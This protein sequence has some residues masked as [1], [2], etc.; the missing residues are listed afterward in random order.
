MKT[1]ML[2]LAMLAGATLG[3]QTFTVTSGQISGGYTDLAQKTDVSGGTVAPMTS[4][5]YTGI[6]SPTG[7]NFPYLA[8]YFTSFSI[9]DN[10]YIV[11]GPNT[12]TTAPA[13]PNAYMAPGFFI[14]PLWADFDPYGN[15]YSTGP[16]GEIGWH[17]GNS[18]LT[19]EWKYLE[20]TQTTGP[21][22]YPAPGTRMQASLNC[23]T[24]VIEFRYGDPDP[25][26]WG[27]N[28]N[29]NYA[30]T[31][32]GNSNYFTGD[33]PGY[34]YSPGRMQVYPKEQYLRFTPY[35]IPPTFT[36]PAT[37]PAGTAG[38]AYSY[39]F[40][41]SGG[42][43]PYTFTS[44]N[45]PAGWSLSS[46][47]LL[48]APAS[49]VTS[50]VKNFNVKL[51]D[52]TTYSTS[53]AFSVTIGAPPFG[54]TAPATLPNGLENTAYAYQFSVQSATGAVTFSSP[55]LPSGWNISASG[56]LSAPAAS[57]NFG[58][59]Q[60]NVTA[61]DSATPPNADTR[62][63][64]VHIDA[65]PLQIMTGAIGPFTAGAP[66]AVTLTAGGG[67]GAYSWSA[68]NLPAGWSLDAASG[69]FSSS[70]ANSVTGSYNVTISVTGSLAG[71]A[72][73]PFTVDIVAP[74]ALNIATTTL[75][76]AVPGAAYN[77]TLAATGGVAP[78]TWGATGLPAGFSVSTAGVLTVTS[79]AAMP[80]SYN[81]TL[82]IMDNAVPAATDAQAVTLTVNAWPALVITPASIPGGTVG[83]PYGQALTVN[84]GSGSGYS[85]AIIGG[86]LPAGITG[87]P[88]TGASAGLSGTPNAA[89]SYS[90]TVEVT[91]G[92]GNNAQQAYTLAV[93]PSGS[94]L[95][96]GTG[97]GGGG[98]CSTGE[99]GSVL[100]VAALVLALGS[101]LRVRRARA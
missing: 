9:C 32:C 87:L 41:A 4:N 8:Q 56:L 93:V 92:A 12:P 71:N 42:T 70:A 78:Y 17:F 97:A 80:G 19:V 35:Y 10:G 31:L 74:A 85:W 13:T 34:V 16:Y 98:G 95:S 26:C 60:F 75:P 48:T 5:S 29:Y 58:D 45:L 79:G 94:A 49:A 69:Q 30:C 63:F 23:T 72:Q 57:V 64:S 25:N 53:P 2:L 101:L 82:T 100:W 3:A 99:T 28:A 55:S 47:G 33:I 59:Y 91:D 76:N 43:P 90:F 18:V 54:I 67:A 46:A 21:Y 50:G 51:Q 14:A 15:Q 24:G 38:V 89:G 37:L 96:G 62:P 6:I 1:W 52:T 65:Q 40:T 20:R 22:T 86:S 7:F 27:K 77:Q 66:F 68:Q 81:L 61:Q 73:Q 44:T 88:T 84:G 36:S 39:Q 11:L 83:F